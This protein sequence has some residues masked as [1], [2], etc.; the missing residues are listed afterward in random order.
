MD[1]LRLALLI[2]GFVAVAVIYAFARASRRRA[3]RRKAE[4]DLAALDTQDGIEF[5]PNESTWNSPDS[6]GAGAS[7]RVRELGGDF[8]ATRETSDAELSVDVSI[9]AGLRAT[10]ES[11]MDGTLE[12]SVLPEPSSESDAAELTPIPDRGTADTDRGTADSDRGTAE[13]IAIDMTRPLVYLTLVAKE[14][15]VSGRVVMDSLDEEGFRPGLMRLYYWR[16]DA[17]PSVT[18]GVANMVEPGILDP[19]ELP[20]METPGLVTFMSVPEDSASAFRILDTMVTVSRRLARRIHAT[21]C[22]ETRSTLTAQAENHLR[23]T[24]VDILR[25]DRT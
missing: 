4:L 2:A 23:E 3:A 11:T 8:A 14:Q 22:D 17:E 19:D 13:P 1:D 15:R 25:L 5:D 20:D 24:V 9:L 21:L 6:T 7:A 12:E 18:F 10:Y 16:S